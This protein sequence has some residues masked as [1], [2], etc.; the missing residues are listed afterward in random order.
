M[1]SFFKTDRLSPEW[2]FSAGSIIWRM[3]LAEPGLLVGECRDPQLKSTS[4][5]GLEIL[6]GKVLWNDLRL[7]D[8]W[9]VG[10]EAVQKNVVLFHG[11]TKPDMPE[12]KGIQ[13]FDTVTGKRLWQNDDVSFWFGFEDRIVAY[14]DLFD[15]RVGY[16]FDLQSGELLKS[17]DTS[18][19]ELHELR[20]R[21]AEA[22]VV[23]DVILPEI[24]IEAEVGKE[25]GAFVTRETKGIERVGAIEYVRQEGL[26]VFNYHLQSRRGAGEPSS[27]ENHL[28]VYLLPEKKRIFTEVIGRNLSSYVPD[29]FFI[30]RP[31]ALFVKDQRVL[32]ALRLWK[33]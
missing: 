17:H 4:F 5:F 27:L 25:L 9:W 3:V 23:P 8:S 24:Y 11:F 32:T 7:H 10:I 29:S 33:S 18:L 12:H 6:T 26:L 28:V 14:R 21:A 19:A 22:Q 30:K 16:E 15:K 2:T 1:F 13:A 20:Q 31:L